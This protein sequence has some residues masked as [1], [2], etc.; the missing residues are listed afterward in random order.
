MHEAGDCVAQL[1]FCQLTY[2]KKLKISASVKVS[3]HTNY[4]KIEHLTYN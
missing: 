3:V 4:E 1:L 2:C